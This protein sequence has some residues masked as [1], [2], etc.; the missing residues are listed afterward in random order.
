M[1]KNYLFE[2]FDKNCLYIGCLITWKLQIV[3]DFKFL[4]NL[5]FK[6]F[7]KIS[8][9]PLNLKKVHHWL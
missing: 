7:I 3:A 4:K 5:K 6:G 1:I 2:N 9:F 8:W